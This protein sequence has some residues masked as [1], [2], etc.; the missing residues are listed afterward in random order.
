[1][2]YS[3]VVGKCCGVFAKWT[4]INRVPG[5]LAT[6]FRT[7]NEAV[8]DYNDAKAWGFVRLVREPSDDLVFGPHLQGVM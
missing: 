2:Y 8:E 5:G 1:K 6:G 3:V 4:L 7:Y